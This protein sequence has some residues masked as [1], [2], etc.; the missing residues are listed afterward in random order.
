MI[1][2]ARILR[3]GWD[4]SE[5]TKYHAWGL[6]REPVAVKRP[7]SEEY[8]ALYGLGT[9]VVLWVS[10]SLVREPTENRIQEEYKQHSTSEYLGSKSSIWTRIST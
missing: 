8:V 1:N 2:L 5:F 4:P 10:A 6:R 9:R 7:L 3:L